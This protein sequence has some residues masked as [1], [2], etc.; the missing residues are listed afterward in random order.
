MG[1]NLK[2][3]RMMYQTPTE[4]QTLP[5]ELKIIIDGREYTYKRIDLEN[6][7]LKL[8]YGLNP[9]QPAALYTPTEGGWGLSK[10]K[11][12]KNAKGGISANNL[13]DGYN[14]MRITA[15]FQNSKAT[16]I[17]K[18]LNP[19]GAAIGE[20]TAQTIR[21]A[22]TID[23]R[24]AYGCTMATNHE[25][26]M[27]A[28]KEIIS[29]GKY[30]ECIFAPKY[31][32]EA[33]KILSQKRTL[34]IIEAPKPNPQ[35]PKTEYH[36]PINIRILGDTIILEE[37]FHT[38]ITSL[39]ALRRLNEGEN[40]G[41]VT[42]RKPEEWEEEWMLH[43]WWICAE[44]SSN[45]VVLWRGNK[46]IAVAC[47][48]QDRISAIEIAIQKAKRNHHETRGSALASDGFMLPDNIPPLAEA[49]ITAII[50]PGGSIH[51]QEII[52]EC[53]RNGITMIF[54]GE[55]IFRHF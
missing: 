11:V 28:A 51:D 27:E 14:A 30:I 46:T 55:R 12:I 52:R 10:M 49:G 20:T 37:H 39:Q 50:Q 53:N 9:H 24:A 2:P 26:D 47:G 33:I 41:V 29:E 5:R 16:S 31:S 18:H 23:Q 13:C 3:L 25:I 15:Y 42:E 48:Q 22:W 43:A 34:R 44:K 1:K 40:T 38:K 17:I 6:P 19:V 32:E 36:T 21:E 35:N 45:G 8:R 7:E 54:T 4:S